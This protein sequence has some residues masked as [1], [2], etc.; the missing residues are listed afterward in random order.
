M[1]RPAGP[2]VLSYLYIHISIY[3]YAHK[4]LNKLYLFRKMFRRERLPSFLPLI[5]PQNMTV[6]PQMV[7]FTHLLTANG[8]VYRIFIQY[9]LTRTIKIR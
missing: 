1:T 6:W 4:M 9:G 2:G 5:E 8:T 7:P 3:L